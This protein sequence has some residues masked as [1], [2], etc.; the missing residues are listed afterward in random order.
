VSRF[1]A[2]CALLI[3]AGT[4]FSMRLHTVFDSRSDWARD[5]EGRYLGVVDALPARGFVFYVHDL[6]GNELSARR[7]Q[8]QFAA[9][10]R[11][12]VDDP[13]LA[14]L[15][16]ADVNDPRQVDLAAARL[17]MRVL[18]RSAD[19]RLAVLAR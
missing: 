19:G 14:S 7:L 4:F 11:V 3:A 9:A 8:A 15:A 6:D 10:P 17:G 5:A 16:I 18:K 13:A 12:V 2:A 1:G